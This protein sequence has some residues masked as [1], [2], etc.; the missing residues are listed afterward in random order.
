MLGKKRNKNLQFVLFISALSSLKLQFVIIMVC[1]FRFGMGI[2]FREGSLLITS[3]NNH[4]AKKGEIKRNKDLCISLSLSN[5]KILI[6]IITK[7]G[8][9][10]TLSSYLCVKRQIL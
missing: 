8:I 10:C 2:E 1:V 3:K 7:A 6:L 9:K 4:V 5:Q